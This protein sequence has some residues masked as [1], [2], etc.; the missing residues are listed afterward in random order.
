MLLQL[1]FHTE[2]S[3]ENAGTVLLVSKEQQ[4]GG[5]IYELELTVSIF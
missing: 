4:L 1:K 2:K 3:M 5:I